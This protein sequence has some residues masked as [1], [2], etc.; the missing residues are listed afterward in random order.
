MPVETEY[1]NLD[2]VL[3]KLVD[4][5]RA[6]RLGLRDDGHMD[7]EEIVSAIPVGTAGRQEIVDLLTAIQGVGPEVER[8][9]GEPPFKMLTTFAPYLT[10]KFMEAIAP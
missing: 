1:P 2:K 10:A 5:F 8:M 6:I 4:S 7:L 9:Q 3:T